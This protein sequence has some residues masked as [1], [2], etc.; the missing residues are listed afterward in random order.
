MRRHARRKRDVISKPAGRR[1]FPAFLDP[2]DAFDH[3]AGRQQGPQVG[4]SSQKRSCAGSDA[5]GGCGPRTSAIAAISLAQAH[6]VRARSRQRWQRGRRARAHA[7]ISCMPRSASANRITPSTDTA[8][9][10][11]AGGARSAVPS[12]TSARTRAAR[13][14]LRA[15]ADAHHHL[16]RLRR[17]PERRRRAPPPSSAA[18]PLPAPISI[19]RSLG[20]RSRRSRARPA[21]AL[22]NGSNT[23]LVHDNVIIPARG[24]AGPAVVR[25]LTS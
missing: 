23:Q 24:A 18:P 10:K 11:L 15:R 2:N 17:S 16:L 3:Q 14:P 6:I 13:Q 8:A 21:N 25:T 12:M 7:G 22:V 19:S 4:A 20:L 9:S 5:G 1:H